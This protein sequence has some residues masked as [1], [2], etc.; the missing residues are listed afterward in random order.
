MSIQ[1]VTP[2]GSWRYLL[3]VVVVMV[4]MVIVSSRTTN[5]VTSITACTNIFEALEAFVRQTIFVKFEIEVLVVV[6]RNVLEVFRGAVGTI[7]T[8]PP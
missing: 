3:R 1:M 7:G 8:C 5:S 6:P 4:M 2:V